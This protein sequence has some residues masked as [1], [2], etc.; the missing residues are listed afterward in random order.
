MKT[1]GISLAFFLAALLF[2]TTTTDAQ[3]LAAADL[4]DAPGSSSSSSLAAPPPDQQAA[5]VHPDGQPEAHQDGQ[6]KR[7]LGIL[8]N[9][10]AV[11]A[12]TH[13][14]PQTITDKFKD[15]SQDSLDYSAIF[16]PAALAGISLGTNSIP[17]FG[18][19]AA[20]YGRYLWR[21]AADQTIENYMVEFVVP[22]LHHED[23]R[24]YT[25]GHGGFLKRTGYAMKHV[26]VTQS[27]S[28]QTTFNAGEVVG[29]AA[30]SGISGAYYPSSQRTLSQFG[31]RWAENLGIDAA[32]FALR[33]FWPDINHA[34][35]HGSQQ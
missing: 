19:G 7:I 4:P 9:F 16:V 28:G 21:A 3:Q 17:E 12:G 1:S 11:S 32:S 15:A 26:L 8:P 24:Y 20:G 5:P 30:A 23:T 29:A 18:T 34:L 14:P 22:V 10:R 31:Q 35:F 25:L 13:L 27:D 2:L 33:E 6:T